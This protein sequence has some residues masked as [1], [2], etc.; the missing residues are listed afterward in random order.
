MENRLSVGPETVDPISPAR[1]SPRFTQAQRENYAGYTFLIPWLVGFFGIT[2]MP[3]IAS[4]ILSFTNYSG[5]FEG[6]KWIGFENYRY[7]FTIDPTYWGSVRVTVLYVLVSV[8]VMLVF[9]LT[10]ASALNRGIK[11]LGLYR[12]AFYVP[13]LLGSSVAIALLWRYVFGQP[14]LVYG[15]FKFFGIASQGWIG[16]P[17]TALYTIMILNVWQFGAPMIIFL[18]GLR[19]VP[20]ELYEASSIDGANRWQKF[21]YITLP[22]L[23]PVILFNGILATIGGFQAFTQVYVVSGGTGGP[24]NST[25]FYTLLLYQRAFSEGRFGYASAMAWM[26]LVVIA[27]ITAGVFASGRFWVNYSYNEDQ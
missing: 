10:I 19:E 17:N 5:S 3:V 2:L 15:V 9:A 4:L 23:S 6:V 11:A 22:S 20:Q 16:D 18:A 24:A 14:G 27:A 7:M 12:T 25:L 13:S 8:P 1:K 21:Q 26:L